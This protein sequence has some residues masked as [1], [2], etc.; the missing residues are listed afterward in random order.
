MSHLATEIKQSKNEFDELVNG[1]D[2]FDIDE[3]RFGH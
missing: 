1:F 3:K 2:T